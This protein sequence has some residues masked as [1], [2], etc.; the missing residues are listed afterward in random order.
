M[1]GEVD[2]SARHSA[3]SIAKVESVWR[4]FLPRRLSLVQASPPIAKTTPTEISC[5]WPYRVTARSTPGHV[6][7]ARRRITQSEKINVVASLLINGGAFSRKGW[8][9][10]GRREKPAHLDA[11]SVIVR[12]RVAGMG[13]EPFGFSVRSLKA[14][15]FAGSTRTGI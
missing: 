13:H 5:R 1:R 6:W 3:R 9:R 12:E 15:V 14:G 7:A 10:Y 11:L 2:N 8:C 4:A